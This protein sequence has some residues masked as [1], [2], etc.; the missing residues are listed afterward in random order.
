LRADCAHVS[1]IASEPAVTLPQPRLG[2]CKTPHQATPSNI[3][4]VH[5]HSVFRHSPARLGVRSPDYSVIPAQA[6]T[7]D[8]FRIREAKD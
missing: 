6:G 4:I 7:Q 1:H 5:R 3:H 2:N 8:L